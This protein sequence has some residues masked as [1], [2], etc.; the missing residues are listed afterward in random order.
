MKLRKVLE[1]ARTSV[2]GVAESRDWYGNMGYIYAAIASEKLPMT[3]D[4]KNIHE[5]TEYGIIGS[6]C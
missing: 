1:G 5:V 4:L 2:K 3:W 6:S